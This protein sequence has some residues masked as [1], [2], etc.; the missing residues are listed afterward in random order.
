MVLKPTYYCSYMGELTYS[1]VEPL[2]L[3]LVYLFSPEVDSDIVR[4][5]NF[6][7][8]KCETLPKT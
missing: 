3:L 4:V 5:A 1:H 8:A 7:S 2:Q 6:L